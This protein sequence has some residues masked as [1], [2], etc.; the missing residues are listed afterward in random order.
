MVAAVRLSRRIARAAPLAAYG[1]RELSPGPFAES[2][3]ALARWIRANVMTTFHFAGTCRMGEDPGAAVD[4][5][6]RFRGLA[7]LRIADASVIPFT[8]VSAL[9]APSMLV[10]Y[11]AARFLREEQAA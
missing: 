7:G 4:T 6:L 8:P 1:N 11:R 2:D 5:R 3:A 10:G 9:N